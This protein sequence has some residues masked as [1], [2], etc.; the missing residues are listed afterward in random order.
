MRSPA[1]EVL[2]AQASTHQKTLAARLQTP[3]SV[4]RLH[5]GVSNHGHDIGLERENVLKQ[6]NR[7]AVGYKGSPLGFQV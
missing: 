2:P 5:D 6:I 3:S 4:S 1:W 7:W